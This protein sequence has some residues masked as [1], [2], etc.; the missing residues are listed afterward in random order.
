VLG[1]AELE[2]L[3]TVNRGDSIAEIAATLDHSDS[4]VSRAVSTLAEKGLV[5]NE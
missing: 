3:V 1:S 4:Y 2:I 5:Y